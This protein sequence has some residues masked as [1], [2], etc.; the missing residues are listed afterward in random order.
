MTGLIEPVHQ[1]VVFKEE[2]NIGGVHQASSATDIP[3]GPVIVSGSGAP[4][5][6]L[7]GTLASVGSLYMDV[8]GTGELYIKTSQKLGTW[9][10]IKN[11]IA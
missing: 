8:S 6:G 7:V 1:K 9:E 5:S 11:H 2:I 3:H 4:A 10:S